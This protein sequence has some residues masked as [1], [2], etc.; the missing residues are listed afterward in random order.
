M[1][2]KRQR[3]PAVETRSSKSP[4]T[5][6][7]LKSF[8]GVRDDYA[9]SCC[10]P[11]EIFSDV[12]PGREWKRDCDRIA[13]KWKWEHHGLIDCLGGDDIEPSTFVFSSVP[14]LRADCQENRNYWCAY[15]GP[16]EDVVASFALDTLRTWWRTIATI[17]GHPVPGRLPDELETLDKAV[18]FADVVLAWCDGQ[19]SAGDTPTGGGKLKPV[20]SKSEKAL[21]IGE[22]VARKVLRPGRAIHVVKILDGFEESGWPAELFNPLP[23]NASLGEAVDNLNKGLSE[24]RFHVKSVTANGKKL[25]KVCWSSKNNR[26]AGSHPL[27]P[28][29]TPVHAG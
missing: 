7:A 19:P 21:K 16:Y 11:R 15:D 27:T 24:L 22:K 17:G 2:K 18:E 6:T 14:E 20:W 23:V 26:H 13:R 8:Q 10:V 25:Q 4:D 28:G 5:S 9:D 1:P 3:K 29:V 12:A